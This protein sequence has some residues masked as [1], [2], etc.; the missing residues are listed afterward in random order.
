VPETLALYTTWYPGIERFLPAWEGSVL[1][2]TDR[3]FDVWIGTDDLD[4]NQLCGRLG[5]TIRADWLVGLPGE[6]PAQIRSRAIETICSQY[7]GVVFVDSDDIL[8]A[9]RIRAAREALEK[10][11]VV[12]CALRIVD[13]DGRD[14]GAQF[15][16]P[17][18]VE[19][20]RFLPRWNVFGLSNSAYRCEVLRRCLPFPAETI[21]I[22]WL[23]VTRAWSLGASLYFDR[24]VRMFYRQYAAN[25]ARV[26]PPFSAADVQAAT[27]RVAGHYQGLLH[28]GDWILSET[29]R[30]ALTEAQERLATFLAAIG[31]PHCLAAYV[32]ALD[33]LPPRYVWWWAVANP[34][35]EAIWRN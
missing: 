31:D 18:V 19:W 35:L 6:S 32:K 14:S 24:T 7:A 8:E 30:F 10:F 26:L 25:I 11:D 15:E 22:D 12:G 5:L 20:D 3:G 23:L 34:D 1:G 21:L 4:P 17:R 27:T 2:Q 33:E 29:C 9:T 16:P 13:G 28:D